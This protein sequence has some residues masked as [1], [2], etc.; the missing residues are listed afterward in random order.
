MADLKSTSPSYNLA[1]FEDPDF[2]FFNFIFDGDEEEQM[3]DESE[4][5]TKFAE[6]NY[7]KEIFAPLGNPGDLPQK[8]EK[9]NNIFTDM[10]E[11]VPD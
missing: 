1:S 6:T 8:T 3:N 2:G 4:D 11:L 5:G 10:A 7:L 9:A